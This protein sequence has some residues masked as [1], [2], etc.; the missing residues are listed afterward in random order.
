MG[1][2]NVV[3][4]AQPQQK[5]TIIVPA[6]FY[7]NERGIGAWDRLI[8]AASRVPIVAI[9]NASSGPGKAPW[10]EF[11]RMMDRAKGS[12]ILL[13]GYV[14][15]SYGRR[16]V[17]DIKDD[18]EKW[19][20]F[21]PAVRGIFLD[22]QAAGSEQTAYYTELYNYI[23]NRDALDIVVSNPGTICAESYFAKH[24]AEVVCLHEATGPVGKTFF[25]DWARKYP[26]TSVMIIPYGVKSVEEMRNWLRL[27]LEKHFHYVYVT[28]AG[29]GNPW[30]GV[31]SYWDE[32]VEAVQKANI[33]ALR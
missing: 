14:P 32:E 16:P 12:N 6:Y 10:A 29:G 24:A 2:F 28:D 13:I 9:V 30:S 4:V 18:V 22:E 1:V 33:L 3:A 23:R 20:R 8:G 26:S 15:T 27:A 7:P 11:G 31:P 5:L 17:R 19:I 25:P 21:Y